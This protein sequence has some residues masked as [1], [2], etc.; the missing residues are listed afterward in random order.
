M[1][2]WLSELFFLFCFV[3]SPNVNTHG[4]WKMHGVSD[5]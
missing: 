3:D 5:R 1:L 4:E 2:V